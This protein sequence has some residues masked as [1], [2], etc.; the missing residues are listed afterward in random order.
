MQCD[1]PAHQTTNQTPVL[2]PAIRFGGSENMSL[3]TFELA[4]KKRPF[5]SPVRFH[6]N[7]NYR[8]GQSSARR[9][10]SGLGLICHR[11]P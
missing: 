8:G 1:K 9:A 4:I 10:R 6:V 3:Q 7:A 2:L 11:E 5:E